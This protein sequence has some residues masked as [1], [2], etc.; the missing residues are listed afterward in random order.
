MSLSFHDTARNRRAVR[1]FLPT[2]LPETVIHEVLTD[3]QFS[4]SNCNTQPWHVHIVMGAKRDALSAALW[5]AYSE[6]RYTPDFSFD[7]KEYF[8]V[9][10]DRDAENGKSYMESLGVAREDTAGRYA[11]AGRNLSFFG[12]PQAAFLFLPTFGDNVRVAADV[13]M[14]GQTFLLSLASRGLAG[15]PQ[16]MLGFFAE[17]VREELGVAD[18]WKLLFGISFGYPDHADPANSIR[19]ARAPVEEAVVFH[20]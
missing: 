12:A 3:A 19:Q 18:T 8:G 13:G 16:T 10:K 15:I 20:H 17:T 6:N 14:Y 2:P 9:Y 4:P 11:A 5:S 1:G 7:Q